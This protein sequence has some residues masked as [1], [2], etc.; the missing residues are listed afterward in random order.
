MN[1]T[2]INQEILLLTDTSFANRELLS[3]QN[4]N[5]GEN[6][7]SIHEKLE[8]ACWDGMLDELLPELAA[9]DS[10]NE[11]FLWQI[12]SADNFLCINIG[13]F[14]KPVESETSID[15]YCFITYVTPN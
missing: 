14:G 7:F 12:L 9:D 10:E 4:V 6:F 15:P 11:R 2:D 8:K 3:N 1:Q 5:K 13:M